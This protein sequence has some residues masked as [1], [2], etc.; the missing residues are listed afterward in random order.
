MDN[1]LYTLEDIAECRKAGDIIT[2]SILNKKCDIENWEEVVRQ[3]NQK[4]PISIPAVQRGLV[5]KAEQVGKLWDSIVKDIPVGSLMAIQRKYKDKY[6]Y[7]ELLDGQQRCNAIRCGISPSISDKIRIWV[8]LNSKNDGDEFVFMVC[9]ESHPW[10]FQK[11]YNPFSDDKKSKYNEILKGESLRDSSSTNENKILDYFTIAPLD[12]AYP[13]CDY[14]EER[15][16]SENDAHMVFVPLPYA[17]YPDVDKAWKEWN[18]AEN[19]IGR[20]KEPPLFRKPSEIMPLIESK[21]LVYEALCGVNSRL[22]AHF[23]TKDRKKFEIPIHIIDESKDAN[24]IREL[25]IRINKQGTLLSDEDAR[26]SELCMLMGIRFK[27]EIESISKGFMPPPRLAVMAVRLFLKLNQEN[28]NLREYIVD[29]PTYDDFEKIADKNQFIKFCQKDLSS[30]INILRDNIYQDYSNNRHPDENVEKVPPIVYLEK[31]DD[32]WLTVLA[33]LAYKFDSIFSARDSKQWLHLSAL[34]PDV[35]CS[36][37]N[38]QKNF[39]LSFWNGIENYLR[40]P[41]SY[42]EL[43]LLDL[44]TIGTV[45]SSLEEG[46]FVYPYSHLEETS[47]EYSDEELGAMLPQWWNWE[48]PKQNLDMRH[49]VPYLS[50]RNILYYAQREYLAHILQNMR[51]ESKELW[52]D[53]SNKPFDIDH[54]IPQNWWPDNLLTNTLPNKQVY[55]YRDNRSKQ[56]SCAG[57]IGKDRLSAFFVYPTSNLYAECKY[58]KSQVAPVATYEAATFVRWRYMMQHILHDLNFSHFVDHINKLIGQDSALARIAPLKIKLAI[59]RYKIMSYICSKCDGLKWGAVSYRGKTYHAYNEF[60]M[61]EIG[62]VSDFYHSL[63]KVLS[64]GFEQQI[65]LDGQAP[66][67]A[68]KCITIEIGQNDV[69]VTTGYRRP[70]M[71]SPYIDYQEYS[72]WT[73]NNNNIWWLDRD[74]CEYKIQDSSL[75]SFDGI[76][77]AEDVMNNVLKFLSK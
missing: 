67:L 9:S 33:C 41:Q 22:K 65:E 57:V 37:S 72:M 36:R 61:F 3:L 28:G 11:N 63:T 1:Q 32:N 7:I 10:G 2:E 71:I 13:M 14:C 75:S 48:N 56:D 64:L 43:S 12:K 44:L 42:K 29:K 23:K 53:S 60:G 20:E 54:I 47:Q 50:D 30:I 26:Y 76:S 59:T 69:N 8:A 24:Y 68:F 35:I 6:D 46:T 31:T 16:T 19:E 25:F 62:T 21:N 58:D 73:N 77:S 51:A 49:L 70:F 74:K 52:G 18:G 17:L 4:M 39:I 55:Y 38:Y 40:E 5:W 34:L 27:A 66:K 45:Y 15:T